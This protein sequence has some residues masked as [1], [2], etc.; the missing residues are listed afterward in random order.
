MQGL[1]YEEIS[2]LDLKPDIFCKKFK[3]LWRRGYNQD[4]N[5]RDKRETY[6]YLIAWK[7]VEENDTFNCEES[8]EEEYSNIYVESYE[9][10]V[11]LVCEGRLFV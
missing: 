4:A 9:E 8:D 10:K 5:V 3:K 7:R 11:C 2:D 1:R 6:S